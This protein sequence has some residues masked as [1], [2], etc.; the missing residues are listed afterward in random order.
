M[1][2]MQ[3]VVG[4]LR[5]QGKILISRRQK[6]QA[7]ADYWEFPGGKVEAEESLQDALIREFK[8][9]I[10]IET[11]HWQPLIFIPWEYEHA[12]VELNVFVCDDFNGEARG[13]EGQ[14][15]KWVEMNE[16][17]NYQFPEANQGIVTALQLPR[18]YMI[19]GGFHDIKDGLNRLEAALEKG[20]RLVQ[21]RAKKMDEADYIAFAQ[22]AIELVHQYR[23]TVLINGKPEWLE[24]LP[25]ADG[26]QLASTA[27]MDFVERPVGK[28][29]L[30][31]VSTHSEAEI[32][33]ALEL[34]ADLILLS[35]VKETSSHPGVPG[36]GWQRFADISKD[37]PVPVYA[38][39]GMKADDIEQAIENGAQGVAAISSFWPQPI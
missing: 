17:E 6:H 28:D 11:S 8:E 22:P 37:I 20:I 19:T 16:L 3:I 23:G 36:I 9:E 39:G 33:K 30:L 26:L 21:L 13:A 4:V 10:G 15:I 7:Y 31:S 1:Q 2:R 27:I 24:Q 25:Q 29:K 12:A 14:Q 38:L 34:K 5:H 18:E 32:A 35:P